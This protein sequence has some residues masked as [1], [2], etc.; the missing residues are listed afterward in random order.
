M[1]SGEGELQCVISHAIQPAGDDISGGH[2]TG[3]TL[4]E[5]F[6]CKKMGLNVVRG[7]AAFCVPAKSHCAIDAMKRVFKEF[8]L[9]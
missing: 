3:A 5:H 4:V 2:N 8:H 1:N 7:D 9:R 6:P